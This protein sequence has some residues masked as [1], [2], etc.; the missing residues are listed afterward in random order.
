MSRKQDI[1]RVLIHATHV[2][3]GQDFVVGRDFEIAEG[4]PPPPLHPFRNRFFFLAKYGIFD[5]ALVISEMLV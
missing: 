1:S 2:G 3:G 4:A 5:H